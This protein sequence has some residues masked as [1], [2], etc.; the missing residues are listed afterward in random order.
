MRV[1]T[2]AIPLGV[3]AAAFALFRGPPAEVRFSQE[4]TRGDAD[5]V[6]LEATQQWSRVAQATAFDNATLRATMSVVLACLSAKMEVVVTAKVSCAN[7]HDKENCARAKLANAKAT[8]VCGE[9]MGRYS[10]AA[11]ALNEQNRQLG[12][13]LGVPL[14]ERAKAELGPGVDISRDDALADGEPVFGLD[15]TKE[16]CAQASKMASD[17]PMI[18]A[19]FPSEVDSRVPGFARVVLA[20]VASKACG[21]SDPGPPHLTAIPGLE[22]DARQECQL[23]EAQMRSQEAYADGR[24]GAEEAAVSP[25]GKEADLQPAAARPL[26]L[27]SAVLPYASCGSRRG[28]GSAP[29]QTCIFDMAMCVERHVEERGKAF[30]SENMPS[31][32]IAVPGASGMSGPLRAAQR[33]CTTVSR[34]VNPATLHTFAGLRRFVSFGRAPQSSVLDEPLRS[35]SCGSWYFRDGPGGSHEGLPPAEQP[36]RPAGYSGFA[37]VRGPS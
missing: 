31:A 37:L 22:K 25:T 20:H 11:Q 34:R 35:T 33:S 19:P 15:I 26:V 4:T 6:E 14:V 17:G 28:P 13:K 9:Q 2:L 21:G 29:R 12:K 30:L 23:L 7:P 3:T 24:A 32:P 16:A 36:F 1:I 27:S 8:S 10:A 5:Q 18:D